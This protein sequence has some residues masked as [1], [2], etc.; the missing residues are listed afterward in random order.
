M[1]KWPW[2][3]ALSLLHLVAPTAHA[4]DIVISRAAGDEIQIVAVDATVDEVLNRL[5]E[6]EGFTIA[7]GLNKS[8]TNRLSMRLRGR[9]D[10]VLLRLMRN[11][12]YSLV[13]SASAPGKVERIVL[14]GAG[15]TTIASDKPAAQDHRKDGG[16]APTTRAQQVAEA[17][18]TTSP[19]STPTAVPPSAGTLMQDVPTALTD[20]G[21][22]NLRGDVPSALPSAGAPATHGIPTP[23]PIGQLPPGQFTGMDVPTA[24][25]IDPQALASHPK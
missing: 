10:D 18:A 13:F 23:S 3:L 5:A 21:G 17:P 11:E 19:G 20:A 12:S 22:N 8:S 6:H 16:G 1:S 15:S 24:G 4:G 25:A 2:L 7:G 14:T 9:V